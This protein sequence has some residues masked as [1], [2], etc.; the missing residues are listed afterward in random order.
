LS[1]VAIP[2]PRPYPHPASASPHPHP[3]IEARQMNRALVAATPGRSDD[4]RPLGP[5]GASP[6][7]RFA[8]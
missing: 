7:R 1:D 6:K 2:H 3:V 8:A 5:Q 4:M